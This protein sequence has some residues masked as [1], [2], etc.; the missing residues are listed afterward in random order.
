[1][2][3][4]SPRS[5][6]NDG[7]CQ[8]VHE[9]KEQGISLSHTLGTRLDS[10]GVAFCT[11]EAMA[12]R[13]IASRVPGLARPAAAVTSY[14]TSRHV[15]A[16]SLR[17]GHVVSSVRFR[18]VEVGQQAVGIRSSCRATSSGATAETSQERRSG[19]AKEEDGW[20][21]KMLYD[22]EC[23]LCMREVSCCN[24]RSGA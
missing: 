2:V 12:V 9:A 17:L 13:A 10:I 16:V 23:P 1:M 3:T 19:D 24:R 6:I 11:R 8:E 4:G 14:V 18:A 21:V 22:G 5:W 20:Q 7:G 15:V